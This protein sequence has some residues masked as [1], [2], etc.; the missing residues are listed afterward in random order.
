MPFGS[1]Y[2]PRVNVIKRA[3]A[4]AT[5]RV[6]SGPGSVQHVFMPI[7]QTHVTRIDFPMTDAALFLPYNHY[8]IVG[9]G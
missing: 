8:S 3:M 7:R 9:D 6:E 1:D 4:Y 5:D 2:K